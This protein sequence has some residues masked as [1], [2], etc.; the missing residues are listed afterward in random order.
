MTVSDADEL[1]RLIKV[2]NEAIGA[3]WRVL[4]DEFDSRTRKAKLENGAKFSADG[5]LLTGEDEWPVDRTGVQLRDL[6]E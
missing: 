3:N 6:S 5:Y 1:V 4:M 2:A